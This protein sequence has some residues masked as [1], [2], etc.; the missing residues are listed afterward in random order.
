MKRERFKAFKNIFEPTTIKALDWLISHHIFDG[1]V[2]PIKLGKEANV[3]LATK[4]EKDRVIKFAVKIYRIS[5]CDFK[6]MSTY[7]KADPRFKVPKRR[8]AIILLWA[9]REFKN[10]ARLFKKHVRVPEPIA[11]KDNVLVMEFIGDEQAAPLLYKSKPSN[12]EKFFSELLKQIRLMLN[13]GLVHGDLSAFNLVNWN[14]KPVLLDLSHAMPLKARIAP[15]L[16]D[17]DLTQINS[18][19]SKLIDPKKPK[20]LQIGL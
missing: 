7:L 3:M 13:A 8:R 2:G 20:I 16:L 11:I 12:P 14:E 1:L 4:E 5:A 10:L 18:F 6:R 9:E 19:F 15:Q 17:R